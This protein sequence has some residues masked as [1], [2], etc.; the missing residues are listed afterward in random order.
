MESRAGPDMA[1]ADVLWEGTGVCT[2][3]TTGVWVQA[4][5]ERFAETTPGRAMSQQGLATTCTDPLTEGDRGRWEGRG[6]AH[7][8]VGAMKEG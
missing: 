5:G 6:L 1:K 7:E 3:G 8:P 4:S 2:R